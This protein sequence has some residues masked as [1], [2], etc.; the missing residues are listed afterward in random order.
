VL[1]GEGFTEALA[2]SSTAPYLTGQLVGEG[3]LLSRYSALAAGELASAAALLPGQDGADVSEITAP[4]C[5]Q[6][7]ATC[8]T[9]DAS[10]QLA[11]GDSY[12]SRLIPQILASDAYRQHGL[13]LITFGAPVQPGET[14]SGSASAGPSTTTLTAQPVGVLLLSPFAH[15]GR[16]ISTPFHPDSPR[17]ALERLLQG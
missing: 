15:G 1:P 16:R 8:P 14:P 13:I 2:H 9:P 12:L 11:S 7:P 4:V 6:S 17:K 5:P 10:T 3:T